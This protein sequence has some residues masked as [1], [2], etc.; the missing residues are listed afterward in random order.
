MKK[1]KFFYY[2][3]ARAIN[4]AR[5]LTCV[6]LRV[7]VSGNKQDSNRYQLTEPKGVK[8]FL[9]AL[10]FSKDAAHT[11]VYFIKQLK[12]TLLQISCITKTAY[13]RIS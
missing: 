11:S 8:L 10:N 5:A 12:I 7:R 6:Y 4:C 13:L 2:D 1:P 3:F 9:S